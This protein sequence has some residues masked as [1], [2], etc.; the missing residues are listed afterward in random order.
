MRVIKEFSSNNIR[1]SVFTWNEKFLLKA[2]KGPMEI[3]LKFNELDLLGEPDWEKFVEG[4]FSD[5]VDK[6]FE[7]LGNIYR[8]ALQELG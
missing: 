6:Q 4:R 3:T 5:Q 1:Y 7:Q 2:E 8:N